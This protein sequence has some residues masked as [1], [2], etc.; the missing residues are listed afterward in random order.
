MWMYLSIT[1]GLMERAHA[2]AC[3]LD[4]AQ[5][6]HT[7]HTAK[8]MM[9]RVVAASTCIPRS[10]ED[11]YQGSRLALRSKHLPGSY[12]KCVPCLFLHLATA[13]SANVRV[14]TSLLD[15]ASASGFVQAPVT[16]KQLPSRVLSTV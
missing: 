11:Y 10:Q 5:P 9:L 16:H 7:N 13:I 2:I 15:T 3:H 4:S 8:Q 1:P 14:P 12:G 6:A